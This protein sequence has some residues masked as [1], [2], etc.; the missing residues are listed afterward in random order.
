MVARRLIEIWR[1]IEGSED[2]EASTHGRIRR[3]RESGSGSSY[4]GRILKQT[5]HHTGYRV[6]SLTVD[7]RQKSIT[8]HRAIALTLLPPP[9]T[10]GLQVNHRDGDKLNNFASNLE[11]CTGKANMGHAGDMGLW[12]EFGSNNVRAKL[13]ECEVREIFIRGRNGESQGKLAGE[14][15]ISQSTIS[16][17]VNRRGWVRATRGIA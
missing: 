17:I 15:R 9:T 8:V 1:T 5:L 11:W 3:G 13:N 4:I 2:Y 6:V 7:G 16:N 10:A 14:Y 12:R